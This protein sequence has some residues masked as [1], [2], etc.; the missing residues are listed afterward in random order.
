MI[1]QLYRE[2]SIFITANVKTNMKLLFI[3]IFTFL[4]SPLLAQT[5]DRDSII[6]IYQIKNIELLNE[7]DSVFLSFYSIVEKETSELFDDTSTNQGSFSFYKKSKLSQHEY[8]N[9]YNYLT[10][11]DSYQ[12][13]YALLNHDNINIRL[14]KDGSIYQDIYLSSI[15]RNITINSYSIHSQQLILKKQIT[16][17]FERYI[18]KLLKQK[19]LWTKNDC[20]Y[21]WKDN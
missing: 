6:T 12:D 5:N 13:Q 8:G 21:N 11:K 4:L 3:G 2:Y 15:T 10:R 1:K 18:T 14:Y 16:K 20:F 7:P 9:L 17:K 19:K